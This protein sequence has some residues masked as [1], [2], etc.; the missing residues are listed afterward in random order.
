M[1]IEDLEE[2]EVKLDY[3]GGTSGTY[4]GFDRFNR[5]I[6]QRWYDY[7]ASEDRDRFKYGYDRA[8]NRTWKENVVSKNLG[9]PIYFDELY[10]YLCKGQAGSFFDSGVCGSRLT[11]SVAA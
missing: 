6:D 1:V 5:I 3:F 9:T 2:P 7:G 4:A 11:Y 10:T 8:A